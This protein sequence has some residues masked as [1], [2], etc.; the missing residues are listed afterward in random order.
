M[1]RVPSL[2]SSPTSYNDV[3][4]PETGERMGHPM[5]QL[6]SGMDLGRC[7]SLADQGQLQNHGNS[8]I[9]SMPLYPAGS[10]QKDLSQENDIPWDQYINDPEGNMPCYLPFQP[11]PNQPQSHSFTFPTQ[12][13]API[14][15]QAAAPTQANNESSFIAR[16]DMIL[17]GSWAQ[18]HYQD[19]IDDP[20]PNNAERGLDGVINGLGDL[21]LDGKEKSIGL[22]RKKVWRHK[23][24]WLSTDAQC[25]VM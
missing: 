9:I 23:M 14:P 22:G 25:V 4:R 18:E 2:A 8:T 10:F 13:D 16:E 17:Q 6:P 5:T 24:K 15:Q 1:H 20:S 3:P 12:P 21:S 11:M 7:A 19:D